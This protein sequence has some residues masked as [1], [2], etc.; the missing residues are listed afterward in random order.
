M[1]TDK[2]KA[3]LEVT[4]DTTGARKG[5]ED[6]KTGAK[7]M[8]TS[9]A[10]AGQDAAKGVDAIG[11][12][13]DGAA[14]K[15]DRSTKSFT[16]SI[17][18]VTAELQAGSKNTAAYFET[19]GKQLG[20]D[21]AV[22]QP[23]LQD[24]AKAQ[25]AQQVAAGSLD[26]M[27]LSAAQ[28]NQSLRYLPKQFDDAFR[29]LAAGQAPVA[30]LFQQG[31]QLRDMFGGVGGAVKAVGG[32]VAG[33][34][35]P[36]T[37]A[38]AAAAGLAI[39]YE[40]GAAEGE[41]FRKTVILTGQV[42]GVTADQLS[43]MA[44]SISKSG[45]GTQGRAA[46]VLN[47][48]AQS[49]AIGADNLKR[50]AAAALE[51]E[52]AG[53]PAAEQ[54]VKAFQDLAK[55]PL[56]GALKLNETTNFLT[57]SIYEEIRSLELQGRTLEAG[58]VAQD[59]FYSVATERTAPLLQNL[60][61]AERAW[62][63]VKDAIKGT[64][65]ALLNIG[66]DSTLDDQIAKARADVAAAQRRGNEPDFYDAAA[67]R[68]LPGGASALKDA[69][70]RLRIL[71]LTRDQDAA[72][73]GEKAKQAQLAKD[74]AA[75][76]RDG[77]AFLSKRQQL[78]MAITK[79]QNEG[80][81]AGASPDEIA[82]RV[83]QIRERF[84]P[85]ITA[86]ES[87]SG[88]NAVK[89]QLGQLTAAYG[90]AETILAA[91]R[92]AGTISEADYYEAKRAFIRLDQDAQVKALQ[93]ENTG[94]AKESQDSKF[95]TAQRIA[96]N[97]K[98]LDN[99]AKIDQINGKAAASTVVLGIQQ[100]SA[101]DAITKA[102]VEAR[103]AAEDYLTT[104]TRQHQLELDL[105]GKGTVARQDGQA[106]SQITDRYD[107][108]Q[109]RIQ[110]QRSA[111]A[112]SQGGSITEDQRKQF[113]ALLSVNKEFKDKA[114]TEWQDYHDKRVAL[115]A[116]WSVGASEAMANYIETTRDVAKQSEELFTRAFSGMEDALVNFIK[117]GKLNFTA[118]ADSIITD[119]IRVQVKQAIVSAS[120]SDWGSAI[121]GGIGMLIGGT[122]G[123]NVNSTPGDFSGS[124]MPDAL[125]GG[126]AGGGGVSARGLYEVNEEGPEVLNVGGRS[127][128]MMGDQDGT[129]T[130]NAS[131]RGGTGPDIHFH[132]AAGVTR[133][134]LTA[135][136]PGIKAEIKAE[137][138]QSARRPGSVLA[139]A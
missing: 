130:P 66:R 100:K 135:M 47:E 21:P 107:Q 48:M 19:R 87:A 54:T 23:Y 52:H 128:L 26:K 10:Q 29:S 41:E 123:V 124:N 137:I 1:A 11:T 85:G 62:L 4:T 18:R 132:I 86:A 34:V 35:N 65:D 77:L 28:L 36:Y 105:T 73:S 9:V 102:Y 83:R 92:A 84:D 68:L 7:D 111:L 49:S 67:G 31:S 122:G 113:D 121:L 108:E 101:V 129:V 45:S 57:R 74:L 40:K 27:G 97:D 63:G 55:A 116:D 17:Q 24:L 44:A 59:A 103:L 58:K 53:G 51:L 133:Q 120:T 125:R 138:T 139:R 110:N 131:G 37:L 32:Y 30:V 99:L 114:L 91:Q 119:L 33:L 12:S 6:V 2:R 50:F 3:Q 96:N 78:E 104:L 80:K 61:Y 38:A 118:L 46:E 43:S 56:E 136:I 15:L 93:V 25:Q 75:W 42:A 13:G 112:I 117:T 79:A 98:I 72:I 14:A 39:A 106:Q 109:R 88:I 94:L 69:Q 82:G 5:F 115:E 16:A 76:D 127:Y 89:R 64:G 126:R 134:E 81:A 70:D 20:I 71:T 60:G 22:L 90:D 8:A 95:S